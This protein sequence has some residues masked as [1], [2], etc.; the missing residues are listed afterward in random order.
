MAK[1]KSAAVNYRQLIMDSKDVKD[2]PEPKIDTSKRVLVV[3]NLVQ[4]YYGIHKRKNSLA[5]FIV[6]SAGRFLDNL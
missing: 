6:H 2:L 5:K 1:K 3:F 4:A